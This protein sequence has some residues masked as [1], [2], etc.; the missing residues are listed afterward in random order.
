MARSKSRMA[1]SMASGGGGMLGSGIHGM[2]G[3]TIVCKSDDT[4]YYCMFSKLLN[5]IMMFFMFAVIL[6]IAYTYLLPMMS[7]KSRK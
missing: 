6:Y 1:S 3:T 7:K 5:S 4:S 2:F